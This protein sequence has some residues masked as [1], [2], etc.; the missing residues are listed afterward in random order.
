MS[1]NPIKSYSFVERWKREQIASLPLNDSLLEKAGLSLKERQSYAALR[2]FEALIKKSETVIDLKD[3][4]KLAKERKIPKTI[5][6]EITSQNKLKINYLDE[7]IIDLILKKVGLNFDSFMKKVKDSETF[8][9]SHVVKG[10]TGIGMIFG[11]CRT[12]GVW[13]NVMI[14]GEK[15]DTNFTKSMP[16]FSLLNLPGAVLEFAREINHFCYAL[17][18]NNKELIIESSSSLIESITSVTSSLGSSLSSLGYLMQTG[19]EKSSF[20]SSM[21]S[22]GYIASFISLLPESLGLHRSSQMEKEIDYI[23]SVTG[24]SLDKPIEDQEYTLESMSFFIKE[25][26]TYLDV[27]PKEE[28][29]EYQKLIKRS[30]HPER[31]EEQ[32]YCKSRAMQAIVKKNEKLLKKRFGIKVSMEELEKLQLEIKSTNREERVDALSKA[33]LFIE[34]VRQGMDKKKKS[35]YLGLLSI[36]ITLIGMIILTATP[37]APLAYSLFLLSLIISLGKI[38]FQTGMWSKF[39]TYLRMQ[40]SSASN[41]TMTAGALP[42]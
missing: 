1:L 35:H 27:D 20:L 31:I 22:A 11:I 42:F 15:I 6:K 24:T 37:L 38:S 12:I 14:N 7:T 13:F 39:A 33:V 21:S 2:G 3:V 8:D 16:V 41:V 10:L 36:G 26:I 25:I 30:K 19:L 5:L 40:N 4:F 29:K 34:K 9:P 32:I 23:L 28:E 17:Y 18:F